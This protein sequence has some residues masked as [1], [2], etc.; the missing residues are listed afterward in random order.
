MA[1]GINELTVG[2]E[3]E[4]VCDYYTYSVEDVDSYILGDGIVYTGNHEISDMYV[5]GGECVATYVFTDMYGAE[6]WTE[7]IPD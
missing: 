2:D 7:E 4:F 1:K 5:D 6:H 3:I